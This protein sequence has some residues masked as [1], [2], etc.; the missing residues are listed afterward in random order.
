TVRAADQSATLSICG[1]RGNV[2]SSSG[3]RTTVPAASEPCG[4]SRSGTDLPEV[5]GEGPAQAL[6][7]RPRD[8]RRIAAVPAWRPAAGHAARRRWR[9]CLALVLAETCPGSGQRS[10]ACGRAGCGCR[11]GLLRPVSVPCRA[12]AATTTGGAY[13]RKRHVTLQG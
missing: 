7:Q 10:G 6:C 12:R 3:R 9:A 5:F 13:V 1:S 8:G 11:V 2:A 4:P